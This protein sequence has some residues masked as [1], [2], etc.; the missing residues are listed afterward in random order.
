MKDQKDK[1]SETKDIRI[2][3]GRIRLENT[4]RQITEGEQRRINKDKGRGATM[5]DE[6]RGEG[7]KYK[8][9]E[10]TNEGHEWRKKR[11]G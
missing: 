10:E 4:D 11:R 5:R 9:G 1:T 7:I 8:G 3:D 2:N 6:R